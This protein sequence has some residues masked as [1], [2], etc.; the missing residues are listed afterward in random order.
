MNFSKRIEKLQGTLLINHLDFLILDEPL[1][2]FYLTGHRVSRGRFCV[3]RNNAVFFVDGRYIE[4]VKKRSPCSVELWEDE[5]ME[6]FFCRG[7][8]ALKAIGF[9]SHFTSFFEYQ[10]LFQFFDDIRRR[11]ALFDFE[12]RAL[13][14]PMKELR[15]IKDS[16]E[17]SAL[18]RS[19][20]LNRKGFEHIASLLKEGIREE[21]LAWE[22]ESYCRE[23]GAEATAFC[24]MVCFGE[25][26]AYPHHHPGKRKLRVNEVVLLDLGVVVQGY[27]SDLTRILFFGR[28]DPEIEKIYSL[29]CKAHSKALSLC[30]PGVRIGDIDRMVRQVI[31]GEGLEAYPHNLGHGIGL[32]IHEYPILSCKKKEAALAIKPGMVFTVEPGIYIPGLGGVR[33]EDTILITGEGYENLYGS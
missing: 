6:N 29:V 18:R 16:E 26:S 23:A 1:N 10:K 11:T 28:P 14:N 17:I 25:N 8:K 32:A 9:D 12:L 13:N 19:A 7:R 33:Y 5:A 21:D 27:C 15:M 30:R 24:P 2:L 22:F 20:T 3:A 4:S 31:T